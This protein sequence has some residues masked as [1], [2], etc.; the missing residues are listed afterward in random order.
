L[1][2]GLSIEQDRKR[3]IYR[4]LEPIH[5][6]ARRQSAGGIILL[7]CTALALAW[8]NSYWRDSYFHLLHVKLGVTFDR[9]VL[10]FSAGHWINDGLMTI[11]FFVVGLEIKREVLVGELSTL[12]QALLPFAAAVGGMVA[13]A[14]LYAQ[15]NSGGAG[16]AGWGIP[17]ATDIAFAIGVLSLVG[18]GAPASLTVFLTALAIVDDLGAVI[19]IAVFYS[20]G[21]QLGALAG[22]LVF[23]LA[24]VAANWLQVR[25]ATVYAALATGVWL[26]LLQSGVHATI[27]GVLAALPIPAG[28][29]LGRGQFAEW[30]IEWLRRF[31]ELGKRP[32]PVR[33]LFGRKLKFAIFQDSEQARLLDQLEMVI[34]RVQ[35]PLQRLEHLLHPVVA[36]LVMPVFAL[37]NAGVSLGDGLSK[38]LRDPVAL[39]VIAGL[40]VGKP[41]GI[42]VTTWAAVKIGLC[43]LP[44]KA[45]WRDIWA[46]GCLAGIGFT[47]SL[48]ITNMAFAQE[49][50]IADSK[51]GILLASAI[52]AVLGAML[53]RG[54]KAG[55]GAGGVPVEDVGDN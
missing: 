22:A 35:S 17:M 50:L 25:S 54:R 10:E 33:T 8:A 15:L 45:T 46:A 43:D 34:E 39:G 18:R 27:A 20:S 13:P 7:V 4:L 19:V 6:F 24:M 21:V 30:G 52:S 11:F 47:M 2:V 3:P 12:R 49:R 40:V 51:V 28:Q 42:A 36:F 29:L 44:A 31:D 1:K 23:L 48:F 26:F 14:L 5:Q 9:Y 41:L 55:N 53:L 38:S 32:A 37:A 16:A